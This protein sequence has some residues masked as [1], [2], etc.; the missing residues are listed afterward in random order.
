MAE[1]PHPLSDAAYEILRAAVNL[2]RFGQYRRPEPLLKELHRR[3]PGQEADI[4]AALTYW[5]HRAPSREE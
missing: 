5:K 1:H 2:A 3:Y 4:Q